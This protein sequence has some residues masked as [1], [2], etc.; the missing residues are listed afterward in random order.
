M[1]TINLPD[2]QT[3][4]LPDDIAG[5]DD[6]LRAALAP[7]YPDLANCNIARKKTG[8]QMTVTVTKRAGTKG[9]PLEALTAAE[10]SL[11]PAVLMRR[12][13][14]DLEIAG[15]LSTSALLLKAHEIERAIEQ[16]RKQI[17]QVSGSRRALKDSEAVVSLRVPEGF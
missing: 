16:G 6:T 7:Y 3:L 12:E 9:G 8:D 5:A 15:K 13:L 2:Q 1:A 17:R 11:N 10:Q 14:L 4:D